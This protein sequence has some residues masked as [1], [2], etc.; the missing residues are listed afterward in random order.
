MFKWLA[1]FFLSIPV[2]HLSLYLLILPTCFPL[3]R[4]IGNGRG[5]SIC[6]EPSWQMW[7]PSYYS[8][9]R[10]A[11]SAQDLSTQ[12]SS[13]DLHGWLWAGLWGCLVF[14]YPAIISQAAPSHNSV[15]PDIMTLL[16]CSQLRSHCSQPG[17][18]WTSTEGKSATN[19]PPSSFFLF[20]CFQLHQ[21]AAAPVWPVS[22]N[23]ALLSDKRS[24]FRKKGMSGKT[25]RQKH[26]TTFN[27]ITPFQL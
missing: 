14:L 19:P 3:K 20:F 9:T 17:K 25:S 27:F 7:F 15:L 4:D 13:S 11:E 12:L 26:S 16:H 2:L 5:S 1:L 24:Y 18:E 10:W 8:L 21:S 22:P 6:A 23:E